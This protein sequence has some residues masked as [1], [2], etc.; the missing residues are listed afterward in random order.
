MPDVPDTAAPARHRMQ[1]LPRIIRFAITGAANTVVGFS[2]LL[3]ALWLG[4][5]DVLANLIGF[6]AGLALGFVANRQW[7]FAMQGRVRLAE[8]ARYLVGFAL[9][10]GL[11]ISVVLIGV[12]AGM[13]GSP[14][15]H[16]AGIAVYSA[17]LYLFSRRFVFI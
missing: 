4:F 14:L 7:T 8:V 13:A 10:W 9:A 11:N 1:P 3:S 17:A 5:S 16:L 2:I 15:I 6:S 12:E